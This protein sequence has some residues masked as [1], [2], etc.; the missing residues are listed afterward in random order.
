MLLGTVNPN[1]HG[2][3]ISRFHATREI[4]ENYMHAKN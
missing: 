2:Y 1:I 4:R 3:L